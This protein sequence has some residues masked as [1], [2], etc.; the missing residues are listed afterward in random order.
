[1]G[2]C[3]NDYSGSSSRS[4][5]YEKAWETE[6]KEFAKTHKQSKLIEAYKGFFQN[7]TKGFFAKLAT[8]SGITNI[9]DIPKEFPEIEYEVKFDIRP[10]G[11]GKEPGLAQYLDAF[12]FPVSAGSRFLKDPVNNISEGVNHF[13][14]DDLDERLVIIEKMGKQYLK[15]K[16]LV[17]PINTGAQ[18]EN[19]VIKRTELRYPSNMEEILNKIT[20]IKK[21]SPAITYRGKIRKEKGDAFL[22]DSSDGRLYSMTVTR[23]HL[24]K[25]LETVESAIQRQLEVEYAG[26]IPGFK[27]MEKDSE[28]QIIEG[29]V[30][31]AK[32]VGVLYHGVPITDG[33]KMDLAITNQRK[34]DFITSR[35]SQ[36]VDMSDV[37][38]NPKNP[39][40]ALLEGKISRS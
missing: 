40:L 9:T 8:A 20:E 21:E 27:G 24:I 3:Y 22:L 39:A 26:F 14:G 16:G 4:Y 38:F 34:Y 6:L 15:E 25:P 18:Y 33:W 35:E 11:K 1:M 37:M 23:A 29:M 17:M 31:I 32:Y 36:M 13:I 30:A 12:E 19:I 5:N 2:G 28:K 7:Q 10:K